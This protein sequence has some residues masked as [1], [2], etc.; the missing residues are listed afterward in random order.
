[1]KGQIREIRIIDLIIYFVLPLFIIPGLWIGY[2]FGI[3]PYL[4][5]YRFI[6]L[7]VFILATYFLFRCF[8]IGLV[9]VYKAFAPLEM[10][11]QCRFTPTCS[12]YMIMAIHKY[13]IVIGVF[14]GLNRIRRCAPPNGGIDYP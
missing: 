11:H 12:T 3:Y 6:F 10:R 5:Y 13:G 9:L 14:K 4:G 8:L 2:A 7:A 1:M